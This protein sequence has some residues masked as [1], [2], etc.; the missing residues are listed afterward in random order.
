MYN[1]AMTDGSLHST[2]ETSYS[3][4]RLKQQL[5]I[6]HVQQLTVLAEGSLRVKM[7][8]AVFVN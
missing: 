1:M 4:L 5:K 3:F 6:R 7:V 8:E 2:P